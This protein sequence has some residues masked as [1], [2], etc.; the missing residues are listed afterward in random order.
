MLKNQ[1]GTAKF[2]EEL[3][4]FIHKLGKDRLGQ[5]EYQADKLDFFNVPKTWFFKDKINHNFE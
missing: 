3:N 2:K 5:Y 4:N 1:R